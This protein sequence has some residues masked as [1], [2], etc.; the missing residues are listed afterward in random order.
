[1]DTR[2]IARLDLKG[3]NLI[4][5]VHLEGLRVLGNPQEYAQKY[6]Q[7][8]IEELIF[9]DIVASLYGRS[10][11]VDIIKDAASNIFVP[12]TVGGGV[13]TLNDVDDLLRSG[14]D[15]IA[16][17]TFAV[18]NPSFIEEVAKRF[19]SQCMVASIEAKSIS[20][21]KW[22]VYTESGRETTGLD[23]IDWVKTCVDLG[24]GEILLTSIDR[25]GTRKG[26]ETD[27][28]SSVTNSINIPVIASGGYGHTRDIPEAINAGA[29][30]IAIADAL[31][32]ERVTVKEL[33]EGYNSYKDSQC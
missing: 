24:A 29:S 9:I 21:Q 10:K 15:K 14:A 23:V 12:L 17:N 7:E 18:N 25:E 28:I 4:K 20:N 27:L 1:M 5:G 30:A 11:L 19:G 26:F 22:E 16:I 2:F 31:H 3:P 32:Y 6:Y 8:E 33:K 13:R